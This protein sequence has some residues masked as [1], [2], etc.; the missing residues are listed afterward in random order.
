MH[1]LGICKDYIYMYANHQQI[2]SLE[3]KGVVMLQLCHTMPC[4]NF[5]FTAKDFNYTKSLAYFIR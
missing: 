5:Y 4:T 3:I 1:K 2:K